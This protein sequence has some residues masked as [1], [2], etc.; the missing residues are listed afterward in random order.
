MRL[1]ALTPGSK[2]LTAEV[3]ANLISQFGLLGSILARVEQLEQGQEDPN[4]LHARK[5]PKDEPY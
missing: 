4:V 2:G 1:A 3:A 5:F